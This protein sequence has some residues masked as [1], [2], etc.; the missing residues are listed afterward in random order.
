M[1]HQWVCPPACTTS[2]HRRS[3]WC[4]WWQ[5][6]R[7]RHSPTHGTL[8]T[9]SRIAGA[10]T[11]SEGLPQVLLACQVVWHVTSSCRNQCQL[12]WPQCC[13]SSLPVQAVSGASQ[14][15]S[16]G[17]ISSS[18]VNLAVHRPPLTSLLL[19]PPPSHAACNHNK[20][21]PIAGHSC[22]GSCR[23]CWST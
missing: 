4:S 2:P 1:A 5:Q 11:A 7:L 13:V 23:L 16:M 10:V 12:V 20:I 21:I 19:P 9:R 3:S 6:C 17:C 8:A 14:V 15:L 18:S 22:R